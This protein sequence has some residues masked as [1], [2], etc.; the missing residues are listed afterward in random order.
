M[1]DVISREV[2]WG[3]SNN[4]KYDKCEFDKKLI[5]SLKIEIRFGVLIYCH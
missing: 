3:K 4:K 2:L 5:F 1:I